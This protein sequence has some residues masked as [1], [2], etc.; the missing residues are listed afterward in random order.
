[1]AF[2]IKNNKRLGTD[3]IT[4]VGSDGN[5]TTLQMINQ[6]S[7]SN[8]IAT[9]SWVSMMLCRFWTWTKVFCTDIIHVASEVVTANVRTRELHADEI[10]AKNI[11]L[12]NEN[13]GMVTLSVGEDGKIDIKH[14]LCDVFLY[15]GSS[16]V[17]EFLYR[18]KD[19][20]A[21]FVGLTPYQTLLGF[22]PFVG[23][24]TSEFNG[25]KCSLLCQADG[26]DELVDK[27]LLFNF[28]QGKVAKS[29]KVYDANGDEIKSVELPQDAAIKQLTINMPCFKDVES[30]EIKHVVLPSADSIWVGHGSCEFPNPPPDVGCQGFVP[31]YAIGS[32]PPPQNMGEDI[33]DDRVDDPSSEVE[34][35]RQY[36]VLNQDYATSTYY[37][38]CLNKGFFT[39]RDRTQYLM[40][41]FMDNSNIL[42]LFDPTQQDIFAED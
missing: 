8:V 21:N 1:M 22:V 18:S 26:T 14:T 31:P 25:Q 19:I 32:L 36:E 33:F 35:L 27:T 30:G 23:G 39:N 24:K 34:P 16:M 20:V 4:E 3:D 41:E 40:V 5:E 9:Q 29:I 6:F 2:D 10:R 42:E 17:R 11:I 38:V 7:N 15:R 28:P 12:T 13:G 37:N